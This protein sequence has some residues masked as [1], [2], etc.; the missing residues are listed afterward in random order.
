MNIY[1]ITTEQQFDSGKYPWCETFGPLEDHSYMDRLP[2]ILSESEKKFLNA[3]RGLKSGLYLDCGHL[4]SDVIRY[5]GMVPECFYSERIVKTLEEEKI[6][7]FNVIH[8]PVAQIENRG[9]KLREIPAPNYY[10]IE[11]HPG[12]LRDWEEMGYV[13]NPDGTPN[14]NFPPNPRRP[15][16]YKASSWRNIDIFCP[17]APL[18]STAIYCTDRIVDL[19][20]KHQWTNIAFEPVRVV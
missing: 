10:L 18:C 5:S 15:E 20:I 4:W 14:R 9:K 8:A 6:P 16:C 3:R 11:A 13:L 19:A 2:P 12:I 7:L 17:D 1:K